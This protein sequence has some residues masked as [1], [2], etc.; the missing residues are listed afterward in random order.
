MGRRLPSL[1][2]G[3]APQEDYG[4]S[5]WRENR[6]SLAWPTIGWI[7]LWIPISLLF[8]EYHP[9]VPIP[10]FFVPVLFPIFFGYGGGH[11]RATYLPA[12]VFWIGLALTLVLHQMVFKRKEAQQ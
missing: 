8:P 9:H 4:D 7:L 6:F 11:F 3:G 2:P 5:W 10:P 1:R 12:V